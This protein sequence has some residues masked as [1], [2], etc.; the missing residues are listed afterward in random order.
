MPR[1]GITIPPTHLSVDI[2]FNVSKNAADVSVAV[3]LRTIPL[4]SP[5]LIVYGKAGEIT[6]K[7][8]GIPVIKLVRVTFSGLPIESLVLQILITVSL[9]F[10]SAHPA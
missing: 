4:H 8:P 9:Y 2:T 7:T 6:L 3:N 1:K 10:C 5:G